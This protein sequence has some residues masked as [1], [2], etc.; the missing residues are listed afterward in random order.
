MS[1]LNSFV[2]E[3]VFETFPELRI[4]FVEC[5]LAWVPALLWRMDK[6]YR[7]MQTE[8]PWLK[9]KPSEYV[10]QNCRFTTQPIEEPDNYGHL[11][12]IF[13]M[14][15]ADKTVMFAADYPHWDND[16]PSFVLKRLPGRFKN[17]IAGETAKEIYRL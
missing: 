13:D 1:H 11:L 3:G 2:C 15:Q 7:G 17:R 9:R 8:V 5:G 14:M 4:I 6:N 12:Q 10:I 16:A